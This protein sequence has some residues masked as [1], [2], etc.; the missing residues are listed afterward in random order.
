MLLVSLLGCLFGYDEDSFIEAYA[1]VQCARLSECFRGYYEDEYDGEMDE[2]IDDGE[3]AFDAVDNCDFDEDK[4]ADCLEE[5]RS[6][7]CGDWY[8]DDHDD[9]W[10]VFDC[11][12]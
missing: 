9:C 7:S 11:R 10:E 8:A 6:D 4:A 5:L 3:D 1:Q 2:C 12:D